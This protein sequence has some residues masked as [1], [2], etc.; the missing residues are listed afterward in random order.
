MKKNN[1]ATT[2]SCTT[3]AVTDFQTQKLTMENNPLPSVVQRRLSK[4]KKFTVN[5]ITLEFTKETIMPN[6][7]ECFR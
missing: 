7:I 1:G 6:S 5:S 3:P 2:E 4:F